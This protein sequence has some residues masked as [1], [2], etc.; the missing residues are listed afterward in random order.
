MAGV[1]DDVAIIR[2]F[3]VGGR[4]RGSMRWPPATIPKNPGPP[5]TACRLQLV[6]SPRGDS[7]ARRYAEC[8]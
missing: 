7:A 5:V 3:G 1:Y 8:T 2:V 4:L 6:V